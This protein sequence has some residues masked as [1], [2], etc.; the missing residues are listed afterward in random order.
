LG[1]IGRGRQTRGK[2][3]KE[4]GKRKKVTSYVW[5][6]L[7]LICFAINHCPG[8]KQKYRFSLFLT[9]FFYP[10]SFISSTFRDFTL[11]EIGF[12]CYNPAPYNL[13]ITPFTFL[14]EQIS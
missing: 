6:I 4:K 14:Q 11:R 9:F 8:K 2:K 1:E 3:I 12:S 5:L 10:L 7:T 13:Q